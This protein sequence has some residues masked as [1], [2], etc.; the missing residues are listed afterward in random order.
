MRDL[1]PF[2][3]V[4]VRDS[5]QRYRRILKQG[6]SRVSALTQIQDSEVVEPGNCI[7]TVGQRSSWAGSN[8][9]DTSQPARSA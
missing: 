9:R 5:N 4:A 8:R 2:L 6:A 1:R 7:A 3:R